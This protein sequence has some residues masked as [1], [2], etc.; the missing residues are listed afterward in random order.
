MPG[1]ISVLVKADVGKDAIELSVT[2][3]LNSDT[4]PLLAKHIQRARTFDPGAPVRVDLTRAAEIDPRALGRLRAEIDSTCI[5]FGRK[6]LVDVVFITPTQ[7]T[8]RGPDT[9]PLLAAS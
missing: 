9:L 4:A 2:G 1:K 6:H 5:E 7:Q 3:S 8:G